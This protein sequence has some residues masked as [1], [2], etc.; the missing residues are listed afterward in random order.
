MASA[1]RRQASASNDP[2][3]LSTGSGSLTAVAQ[4]VTV[5]DVHRMTPAPNPRRT[6]VADDL[7]T[8]LELERTD[9]WAARRFALAR[10]LEARHEA[11]LVLRRRTDAAFAGTGN[12][13]DYQ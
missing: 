2:V 10:R 13:A 11:R 7:F 9:E 8:T 4:P 6:P 5:V 1:S 3:R 12:L